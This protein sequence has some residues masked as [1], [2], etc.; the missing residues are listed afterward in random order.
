MN[1]LA[2]A[3]RSTDNLLSVTMVNAEDVSTMSVSQPTI[4]VEIIGTAAPREAIGS[5]PLLALLGPAFVAAVAYVDPGNVATN[6]TAGSRYGYRLVWVVVLANLF[7]VLTQ[8]LSAKLGIATGKSL[9]ELCRDRFPQPVVYLL[10]FQAECIALATDL[11]EVLG[12][13]IGL[14][15]LFGMPML[16]GGLVTGALSYAVLAVRSRY[17]QRSFELLVGALLAAVLVGFTY[18]AVSSRPRPGSLVGGMV[19]SL[20][21]HGGLLLAAGIMGATIMP[22]AIHLHTGLIRDRFGNTDGFEVRQRLLRAT[23]RDVGSA[24]LLAGAA[25]VL[26]LTIGAGALRGAG[27][28]TINGTY[29]GLNS[30]LGPLIA[31]MFGLALL[32]SGLV[33]SSVGTYAGSIILGGFTRRSVPVPVRRLITMVP[34]VAVLC[35]GI[36]PTRALVLSQVALSLGLPFTLWPLVLL[37]S[38]RSVMGALVNRRITVWLAAGTAAVISLL[39]LVTLLAG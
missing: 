29:T 8:Y 27:T 38:R 6:V 23:R 34:A 1:R 31:T 36:D 10:W 18:T 24:M 19:P 32:A 7:A 3:Y 14:Y 5:R 15:L 33:S 22:H 25:N 39:G 16:A 12:G 4:D 20:P 30:T 26:L 13:A 28:D 11:A 21:G 9:P 17:G 35:I 37:T 2:N